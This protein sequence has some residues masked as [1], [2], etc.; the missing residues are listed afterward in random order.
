MS[1]IP[2]GESFIFHP[3]HVTTEN[4][5]FLINKDKL[6]VAEHVYLLCGL[7][8]AVNVNLSEILRGLKKG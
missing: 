4:C 5:I 3:T 2:V 1:P 7:K 8:V 6:I